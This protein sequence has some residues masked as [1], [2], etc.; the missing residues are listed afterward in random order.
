MY[1][2]DDV[3]RDWYNVSA[4]FRTFEEAYEHSMDDGEPPHPN[5]VEFVKNYIGGEDKKIFVRFN[6]EKEIVRVD[7]M[8]Y[9]ISTNETNFEIFQFVFQERNFE[10]P[11]P[12]KKGDVVRKVRGLYTRPSCDYEKYVLESIVSEDGYSVAKGYAVDG[13]GN[14]QYESIHGFMDLEYM[15][16]PLVN[17]D[18]ILTPISK[19]LSG[20]IDLALLLG[21]YRYTFNKYELNVQKLYHSI[22]TKEEKKLAGVDNE[23]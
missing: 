13:D 9:L 19:Y 1:F 7:E 11:V 8:N 21:A 2:D 3:D 10:F 16:M 22:Y 17:K 15:R 14:I 6:L 23:S 20:D 5:F 18:I 12:F 4:F